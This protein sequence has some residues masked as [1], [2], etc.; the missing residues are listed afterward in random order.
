VELSLDCIAL[1]Y[2]SDYLVLQLPSAFPSFQ[3]F[4]VCSCS[5]STLSIVELKFLQRT[6]FKNKDQASAMFR[7]FTN[8]DDSVAVET[9]VPAFG[10]DRSADRM[11]IK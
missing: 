11:S 9:I 6:H 4:E 10:S 2:N 8:Y 3:N 7:F 5:K 1:A